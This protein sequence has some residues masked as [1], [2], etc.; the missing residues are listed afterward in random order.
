MTEEK[1]DMSPE[2]IKAVKTPSAFKPKILIIG[3]PIFIVQLVLV[4]FITANIFNTK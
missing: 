4:Y 3:L 1:T 2:I